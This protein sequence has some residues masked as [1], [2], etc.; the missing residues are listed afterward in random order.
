MVLYAAKLEEGTSNVAAIAQDSMTP[1]SENDSVRSALSV[2]WALKTGAKK[3]RF[4]ETQRKYLIDVFSSGEV[5]G[6]KANPADV[7]KA[8]QKAENPDGTQM[9]HKDLFLTPQQIT[10]F[11]FTTSQ[12]ERSLL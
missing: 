6:H 1:E 2:G 12:E 5:T 8:M 3:K 10:G 7:S 9:F 4:T 11:F